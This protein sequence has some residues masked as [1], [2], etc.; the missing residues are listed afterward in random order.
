MIKISLILFI[1]II[2]IIDISCHGRLLNPIAR[3][4][5]WRVDERFPILYDDHQMYCGGS[6]VQW[7]KN[8]GKCGI[9]GEDYSKP[10]EFEKGGSLYRGIIVKNYTENQLINVTIEV[11]HSY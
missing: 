11:F 8:D 5:A 7:T 2:K 10:K 4:S 6:K 9:C 3:S 1:G